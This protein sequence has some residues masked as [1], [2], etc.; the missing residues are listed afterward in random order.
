[1]TFLVINILMCILLNQPNKE[2]K[3]PKHFVCCN[4]VSQKCLFTLIPFSPIEG[5]TCT[6][7]INEHCIFL[8]AKIEKI[9]AGPSMVTPPVLEITYRG[10]H[11]NSI[12]EQ[13]RCQTVEMQITGQFS[14]TTAQ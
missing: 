1:M 9:G 2:S 4:F 11:P 10:G 12:E 5:F 8:I 3:N 7:L 13:T 14:P 6:A